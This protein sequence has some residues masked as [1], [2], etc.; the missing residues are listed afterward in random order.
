M[1]SKIGVLHKTPQSSK[2][3]L[4]AQLV[5][6]PA[7]ARLLQPTI[8]PRILSAGGYSAPKGKDFPLHIHTVWELHY[9]RAGHI[10][11]VI[12]DLSCESQPGMATLVPPR[13]AHGENAWT[14]YANYYIHIA[15]PI[16]TAWPLVIFDDA[17]QS[18][19]Q[20]C[21]ACVREARLA[22][23]DERETMLDALSVQLNILIKRACHQQLCVD[24]TE[25]IVRMAEHILQEQHAT[26][27]TIK[28]VASEIGVSPSHL[29]EQFKRLR[30]TT[31]MHRLQ[32]LRLQQALWWL[33]NS[34]LTLESI[35]STCGYDSASHLSR[36][37]KRA[38]AKSPGKLRAGMASYT[39][40]QL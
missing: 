7:T 14:D 12:A 16:S 26:P 5:P 34:N 39:A 31:P 32:E 33:R 8:A 19:M 20:V 6:T 17:E 29:R 28:Q 37:V 22:E 10:E 27:L 36:H 1:H 21:V 11:C 24:E 30:G 4:A 35:A 13:T 2:T 9:Y 23:S 18:L 25:E 3:S 40:A 38:T 15:A